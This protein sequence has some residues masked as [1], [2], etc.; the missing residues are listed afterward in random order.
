MSQLYDIVWISLE[1]VIQHIFDSQPQ[2]FVQSCFHQSDLLAFER[3]IVYTDYSVEVGVFLS[4][5]DLH[6]SAA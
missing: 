2:S 5:V 4:V 1:E 3:T 6:V